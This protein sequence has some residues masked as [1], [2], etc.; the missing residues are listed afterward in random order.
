MTEHATR[1][2]N[3]GEVLSEVQRRRRWNPQG[4]GRIVEET[5]LLGMS[6]SLVARQH[7]ISGS[8]EMGNLRK[9][10][11]ALRGRS[12]ISSAP[13][14]IFLAATPQCWPGL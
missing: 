6:V 8:T 13:L 4:R 12:D 3:N 2:Y 7:G 1:R 5:Y 10:I 9:R 14:Q 11:H